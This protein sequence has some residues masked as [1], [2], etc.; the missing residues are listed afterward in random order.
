MR[1]EDS[2]PIDDTMPEEQLM[3]YDLVNK[4]ITTKDILDEAYAVEEEKLPWYVNL[5]N[6]LVSGM[7]PQSQDAYKKKK[8]FREVHYYY[9][10]EPY[11]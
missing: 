1:I 11:L 3:F 4:N 6:Y 10:D 7:I 8:F 2:I 5:V 9:W